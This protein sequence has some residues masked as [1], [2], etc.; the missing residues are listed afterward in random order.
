MLIFLIYTI[1]VIYFYIFRN[2]HELAIHRM[3]TARWESKI[4]ESIFAEPHV[5]NFAYPKV[6][7]FLLFRNR[8]ESVICRMWT[9][10]WGRRIFKRAYFL[11]ISQSS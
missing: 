10:R 4:F 3:G 8:H 9:I 2:H 11:I 6:Y 5:G 1:N 7:I